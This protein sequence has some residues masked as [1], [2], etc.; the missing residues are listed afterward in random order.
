[1]PSTAAAFFDL[2]KTLIEGSSA[3][4]FAR[5]SF[6]RGLLSRRQMAKDLMANVRF[7]LQGSTDVGTEQL[8]GRVLDA[9][10]GMRQ[11]DLARIA[12][13]VLATLLPRL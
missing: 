13:D 10:A 1:V 6:K 5:A 11:R 4:D 12:P 7:R 2:D 8:R 9:I 3:I